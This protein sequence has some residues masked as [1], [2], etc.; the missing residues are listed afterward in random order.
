MSG[1]AGRAR[2]RGLVVAS[3]LALGLALGPG[4]GAAAAQIAGATITVVPPAGGDTLRS[5]TPTFLVQ[6]RGVG[7][8]LPLRFRFRIDT[9]RQF[10]RPL[11]DTTLT[12][13][14]SSVTVAPARALSAE[15]QRVY[16]QATV[17]DPAGVEVASPMGG[18]RVVPFWVSLVRPVG[19]SGVVVRSRRPTF[20]WQSPA[21][22]EPPGPWEYALTITTL[23][24]RVVAVDQLRDTTYTPPRDLEA[25]ASYRWAVTARLPRSAQATQV[26]AAGTF[27]VED[28]VVPTSTLLYQNFPNP[29]PQQTA[30]GLVDATCIWFDLERPAR[31]RLEIYDLRGLLVRRLVP[32]AGVADELPPGRYGRQRSEANED[33]DQSFRW[34][35][36]DGG[37]RTVP[38]G[39]YL[40]RFRADGV[41][42][43][44]KILFRGR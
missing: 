18:P 22:G 36:T 26:V 10:L 21:V 15:G 20:V 30:L 31:V 44:K 34:D 3:G 37:G 28:P 8:A 17:L 29:F 24:N 19:A 4:A 9:T 14:D 12:V 27:V 43:V 16:W 35:G 33:C 23:G 42:E 6:A 13:R 32:A 2:R 7:P 25:N 40:L 11:L 1:G 41:E 38:A 39:V 5:V